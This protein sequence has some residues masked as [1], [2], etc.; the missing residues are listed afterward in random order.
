MLEEV[1]P[2]QFLGFIGGGCR[3]SQTFGVEGID[4]LTAGEL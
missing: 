1:S 4:I 2:S 3:V